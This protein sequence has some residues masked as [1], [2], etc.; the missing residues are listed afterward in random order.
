MD[1]APAKLKQNGAGVNSRFA[2]VSESDIL[3][4]TGHYNLRKHEESLE[5]FEIG[6]VA[7]RVFLSAV[8]RQYCLE[9]FVIPAVLW[10]YCLERFVIPAVLW[11]YCLERFV[12]PAVLWQYYLERSSLLS[13]VNSVAHQMSNNISRNFICFVSFF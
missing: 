2:S 9:R 11:E 12:I 8:L 1:N 7:G 6:S 13:R 3:E 10:E 5:R 4:N